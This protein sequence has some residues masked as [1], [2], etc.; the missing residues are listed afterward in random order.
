M[1]S[2]LN[3][4]KQEYQEILE[5]IKVLARTCG[6]FAEPAGAA[7]VA[8][9]RRLVAEGRLRGTERIVCLVT[10]SGLKD[11]ASAMKVAGSPIPIDPDPE[12]LERAARVAGLL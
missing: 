4:E 6:V 8:G 9:L 10:G 12:A 2:I 7:S 11:V 1:T 3:L 5:T